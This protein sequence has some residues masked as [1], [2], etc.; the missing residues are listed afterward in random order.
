M[1]ASRNPAAGGLARG[2]NLSKEELSKA[3]RAAVRVRWSSKE[4]R[5]IYVARARHGIL[6]LLEF[7]A[8]MAAAGKPCQ[9]G[10]AARVRFG[11][12]L[13]KMYEAAL[14]AGVAWSIAA[15]ATQVATQ[16]E[17]ARAEGIILT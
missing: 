3:G 17:S 13:Q 4:K 1:A 15:I 2:R 12:K 7:E 5:A 6:L 11:W 14:G 16:D 9:M 8:L 10:P